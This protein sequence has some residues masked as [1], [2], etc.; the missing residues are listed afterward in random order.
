MR[1]KQRISIKKEKRRAS[2]NKMPKKHY[3]H[4]NKTIKIE[5]EVTHKEESQDPIVRNIKLKMIECAVL[6]VIL[7]LV[8]IFI[9]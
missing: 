5:P 3:Q 9:D 1:Q 8:K 6:L 2:P 7:F 4:V